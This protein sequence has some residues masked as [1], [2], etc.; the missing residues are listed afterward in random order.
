MSILNIG[1][2]EKSITPDKKISLAGQF[3]ERISQ[4]VEKPLTVTAFAVDS[5]DDQMVM[6]SCDLGSV[7]YS[8]LKAVRENITGKIP[9]LDCL[10]ISP[11]MTGLHT[12]HEKLY[13]ASTQRIWKLVIETLKR[14]K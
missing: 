4:Y 2:S 7:G 12:Y 13:I 1:W 14:M 6:V 9:G 5:G 3:A 11:D 8:L 10:C